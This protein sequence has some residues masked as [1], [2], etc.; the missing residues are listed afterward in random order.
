MKKQNIQEQ[1]LLELRE[2]IVYKHE[3]SLCKSTNGIYIGITCRNPNAR[4]QNGY[5]YL[6]KNDDGSYKQPAMANAITL[7]GWENFTHEILLEGL[8]ETEAKQKEIELIDYYDSYEHGL[9]CTRG[10]DGNA[11]F[12][13]EKERLAH[14]QQWWANYRKTNADKMR[15]YQ[16]QYK[17]E[18]GERI[19]AQNRRYRLEHK[20]ETAEYKK[21]YYLKN[22][23]KL[24][25]AMTE[26]RKANKVTIAEHNKKYHAEHKER[27]NEKSKQYR[28]QHKSELAEKSK[29]G[30][31]AKMQLLN[32]LRELNAS[33]PQ[34]LTLAEANSLRSKDTCGG[35]KRLSTLLAKFQAELTGVVAV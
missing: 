28:E 27:L 13:T 30:R 2:Y 29:A 3:C 32:Q 10:G 5:G 21:Q 33:Y 17:V 23:E 25:T 14:Q 4:W 7:H 24:N 11:K 15:E 35:K 19:A 22:K 9:N 6:A 12:A 34:I 18:N 1:C 8:T 16:K 26:Y 31:E 20:Y